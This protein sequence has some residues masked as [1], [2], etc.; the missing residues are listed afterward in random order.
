MFKFSGT[1]PDRFCTVCADE[2][3][4]SSGA[5]F[6][7]ESSVSS[8]DIFEFPRLSFRGIADSGYMPDIFAVDEDQSVIHTNF[9]GSAYSSI[10]DVRDHFEVPLPENY[11]LS[12]LGK[13]QHIFR[14][15]VDFL[16]VAALGNVD[17]EDLREDHPW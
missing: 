8:D 1:L 3:A 10:E 12:Y 5:T 14:P 2:T 6:D 15:E 7:L 17:P 9:E 11:S 16:L 13:Y 4:S